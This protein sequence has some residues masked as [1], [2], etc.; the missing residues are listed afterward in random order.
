MW[1]SGGEYS[2]EK[3]WQMSM[4]ET[5]VSEEWQ[6]ECSTGSKGGGGRDETRSRMRGLGE[7]GSPY[8]ECIF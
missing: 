2:R 8:R 3:E 1:V 7:G 4:S 6:P 5:G